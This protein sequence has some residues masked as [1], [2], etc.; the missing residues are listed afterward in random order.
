MFQKQHR[1]TQSESNRV[2]SIEAAAQAG[3]LAGRRANVNKNCAPKNDAAAVDGA[4]N[5]TAPDADKCN[6]S[7]EREKGSGRRWAKDWKAAVANTYF[8]P[9]LPAAAALRNICHANRA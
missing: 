7:T 3:S 8:Q 6:A 9:I 5:K 4:V 2:A 1:T